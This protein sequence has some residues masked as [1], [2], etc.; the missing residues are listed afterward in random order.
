MW[1]ARRELC[2]PRYPLLKIL[3]YLV[4]RSGIGFV[5]TH[6]GTARLEIFYS[7]YLNPDD[8][9]TLLLQVI[10][11]AWCYNIEDTTIPVM[12]I[13]QYVEQSPNNDQ[14]RHQSGQ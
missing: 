8:A 2:V 13:E 1:G 12:T 10:I 11:T 6:S 4:Q 3:I 14:G 9:C 7:R 5:G